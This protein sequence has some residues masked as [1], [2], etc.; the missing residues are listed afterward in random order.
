[1][2]FH[3]LQCQGY[4]VAAR[5]ESRRVNGGGAKVLSPASSQGSWGLKGLNPA[6][7]QGIWGPER[8]ESDQST[9]YLG[10]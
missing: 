7:P 9:G 2:S 4:L 6:S 3:V 8:T 5:T 10:T 1:M